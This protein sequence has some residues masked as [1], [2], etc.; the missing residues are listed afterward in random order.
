MPSSGRALPLEPLTES[1]P[2][3]NVA[4]EPQSALDDRPAL[5]KH[6]SLV[7]W[8][9]DS[10]NPLCW[11]TRRK[12]V[13]CVVMTLNGAACTIAASI[14]VP[15]NRQVGLDYG[16]SNPELVLLVTTTYLLGQGAGPFV[17]GA[18]R[19]LTLKLTAQVRSASCMDGERL[20][21]RRCP[22]SSSSRSPARSRRTCQR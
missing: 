14:I 11:P 2:A 19:A 3:P 6:P 16:E 18:T 7:D 10:R 1:K 22:A 8:A 15:A 20:L 17:F 13:N 5:E 4:S 12:L 9:T 21:S